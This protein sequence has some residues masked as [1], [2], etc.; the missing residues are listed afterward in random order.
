MCFE[1]KANA[2]S[3]WVH[4]N[5]PLAVAFS[6][7]VDSSVLAKAALEFSPKNR[8]PLGFSALSPTSTAESIQNARKIAQEIG[9]ELIELESDELS[10]TNFIQNGP[11][12]CYFCKK[13]RFSAIRALAHRRSPAS[14]EW[15]FVE[16]SNAD[17]RS[18]YRPG[19]DAARET[20][21]RAPLAELGFTKA[22]IRSLAARWS[23]TCAERPSEPCL[24]TRLAYGL[25]LETELLR[26]VE[27]GERI[28]REAGFPVC[29]LRLETPQQARI[30]VAPETLARLT[31][32][33]MADALVKKIAALGFERVAIDPEGYVSGKMNRRLPR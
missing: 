32:P 8:P 10:D 5:A 2:L 29:R 15:T 13:R 20:D 9:L 22:E 3:D 18:D 24:A 19:S 26:K 14:G 6:G 7:G 1:Q 4:L 12:R 21:F 11:R 28:L 30:E 31:D 23:L 33:Q 17:D 16:G 25:P 27:R